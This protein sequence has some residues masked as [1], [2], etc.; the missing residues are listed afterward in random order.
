MTYDD[1]AP[2]HRTQVAQALQEYG[3]RGTFYV[4]L[5]ADLLENAEGWR[6]VAQQGHE[7]G[8]HSAFHPCRMDG[9]LDWLDD[10]FNLCDYT[11]E[12]FR[13]ELDLANRVLRLIDGQSVRS[14]GATCGCT[15]IGRGANERQ[16]GDILS[17]LF[18]GTRGRATNQV[19]DIDTDI[20]LQNIG[21]IE[22][23]DISLLDLTS[24][25]ES[26]RSSGGWAVFMFHG[27]G[28]GTHPLYLESDVHEQFLAHL[29]QLSG[30]VWVAPFKDVAQLLNSSHDGTQRFNP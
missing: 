11:P 30:T 1:A 19:I 9:L 17:K 13:T 24:Y 20:D 3:M 26:A 18:I 21:C 27:I 6:S 14:Y 15:T 28:K 22:A 10:C 29:R 23:H 8:N 16:V 2:T 25:V 5:R 4:D 7:L 12:R